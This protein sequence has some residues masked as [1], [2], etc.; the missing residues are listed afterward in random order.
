MFIAT[1]VPRKSP[2]PAGRHFVSRPSPR[3]ALRI[4]PEFEDSRWL[5]IRVAPPELIISPDLGYKHGAPPELGVVSMRVINEGSL[6]WGRG[7]G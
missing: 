7:L 3:K 5:E 4:F 6:S 1:Q 2:A